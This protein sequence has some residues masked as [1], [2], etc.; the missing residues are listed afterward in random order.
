M[1]V[2]NITKKVFS[3]NFTN[4]MAENGNK[5][6][7]QQIIFICDCFGGVGV[8]FLHIKAGIEFLV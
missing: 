4:Y 5:I 7:V 2:K 6:S 3:E 1:N 8:H